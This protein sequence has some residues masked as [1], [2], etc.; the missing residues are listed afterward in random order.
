[1]SNRWMSYTAAH[2]W[3][4]EAAALNVSQ[5]ARSP[6]GFM[7]EFEKAGSVDAMKRRSLPVGVTGGSTWEVKRNGFV[8]RHMA[9][10][11]S[12]PTYKRWL[13]LVMWAY[14]PGPPPRSSSARSPRRKT[15]R[16]QSKR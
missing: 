9:S 12:H 15:R 11:R 6:N 10:Y 2:K 5:V 8:A 13:A 4:P 14:M 7:R 3:E 1:M 16:S